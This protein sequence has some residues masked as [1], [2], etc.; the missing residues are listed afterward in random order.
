MLTAEQKNKNI[1]S[2]FET[3]E[4]GSKIKKY[5]VHFKDKTKAHMVC[6][7]GEGLK[8]ATQSCIDRFGDKVDYVEE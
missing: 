1:L 4:L 5:I 8:E 3:K 6:M 2:R 7:D